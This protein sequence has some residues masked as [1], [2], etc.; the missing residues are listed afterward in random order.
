MSLSLYCFIFVIQFALSFFL[1]PIVE[2][3]YIIAGYCLFGVLVCSYTITV[4]IN[5]GIPD[6]KHYLTKEL[7]KEMASM[8]EC[9]FLACNVCNVYVDESIKVGHCLACKVCIIGYD[10]HCGWSSKCIG[11]GNLKSFWIFFVSMFI[12]VIYSLFCVLFFTVL[13]SIRK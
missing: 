2:Y 7:Q 3:H 6:E 5:P 9:N 4:L 8:K 13:S 10:H 12:F 11:G 1:Y